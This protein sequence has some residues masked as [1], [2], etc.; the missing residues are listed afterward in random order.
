MQVLALVV[1]RHTQPMARLHFHRSLAPASSTVSCCDGTAASARL[2]S[3]LAMV[4][5]PSEV[6]VSSA[7]VL[8]C[9]ANVMLGLAHAPPLTAHWSCHSPWS[10]LSIS[11]VQAKVSPVCGFTASVPRKIG[12]SIEPIAP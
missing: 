11:T 12:Q 9:W 7:A 10:W 4:A 8:H 1:L 3:P 2:Y 6:F 5:A